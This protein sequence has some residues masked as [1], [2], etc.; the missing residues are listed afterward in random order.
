M[1]GLCLSKPGR[2]IW[3]MDFC[4]SLGQ[5]L[6]KEGEGLITFAYSNLLLW[7]AGGP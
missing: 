7:P 3:N 2:N 5:K 1:S 6:P 4:P